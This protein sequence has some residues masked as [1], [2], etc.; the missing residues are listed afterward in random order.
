MRFARGDVKGP[1]C[2]TQ[3]RPRTFLSTLQSVAA[4][5]TSK[6]QLSRDFRCRPIFDFCNSICHER[7]HAPQQT[8]IDWRRVLSHRSAIVMPDLQVRA[9][10]V[11]LHRVYYSFDSTG[12]PPPIFA[13]P[14]S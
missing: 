12:Y 8:T 2:F 10:L 3:K 6:N 1:H 14:S 4:V 11:S 5:G 7:T 9:L 13:R